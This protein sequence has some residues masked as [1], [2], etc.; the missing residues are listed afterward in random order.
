AK[1][2][3]KEK[4]GAGVI[5]D[6]KDPQ[7]E[8][9]VGEIKALPQPNYEKHF[10]PDTQEKIHQNLMEFTKKQKNKHSIKDK[11]QPFILSMAGIA[12]LLIV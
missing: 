11:L 3:P 6:H 2:A 8:Q 5:K 7:I 10:H 4:G 12:A 1:S 9:L